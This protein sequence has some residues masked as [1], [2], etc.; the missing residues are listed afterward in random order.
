MTSPAIAHPNALQGTPPDDVERQSQVS[1]P[2]RSSAKVDV[3]Q[4]VIVSPP[5]ASTDEKPY[6]IFT[7]NEKWLIVTLA[8]VAGLFRYMTLLSILRTTIIAHD[9]FPTVH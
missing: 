6:S 9:T 1:L 5:A 3:Q 4:E 7:P 8:S 2:A